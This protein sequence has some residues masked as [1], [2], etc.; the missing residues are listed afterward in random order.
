MQR[1]SGLTYVL[2]NDKRAAESQ[3]EHQNGNHAQHDRRRITALRWLA[4]P[5]V[6]IAISPTVT[7]RRGLF[8][9]ASSANVDYDQL[10][11]LRS[12]CP[13]NA[14]LPSL[15]VFPVYPCDPY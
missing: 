15:L 2:Q 12:H 13:E 14:P 1:H 4:G 3:E 7:A 11:I 5:P 10:R 8:P 6:L 9:S